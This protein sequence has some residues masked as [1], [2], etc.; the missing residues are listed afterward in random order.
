MSSRTVNIVG[1]GN[2]LMGD[3]GVG[4]AAIERLCRAAVPEGVCLYDAGLAVSDVVGGLSPDDPLIVI[5]ALRAGGQAGDV[6]R[7]ALEDLHLVE[8]SLAGA[9]SLHELSVLPALRIEAMTGRTFRNVTVFGIEPGAVE[10]GAGLSAEAEEALNE[11]VEAVLAC[12]GELLEDGWP[13]PLCAP[14]TEGDTS[15]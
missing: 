5:D 12:A 9:M 2:V 10:W 6:Y 14:A 1:V 8:G 7:A 13:Q 11:L 3:D 15:P 4:P